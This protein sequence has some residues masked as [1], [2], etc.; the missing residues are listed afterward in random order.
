MTSEHQHRRSS[1]GRREG[2][3]PFLG[4]SQKIRK[5]IS[6]APPPAYHGPDEPGPL[7]LLFS[8]RPR[9]D[10]MQLDL[11]LRPGLLRG[12][13][14]SALMAICGTA[15]AAAPSPSEGEVS[16]RLYVAVPGI[17]NYLEYGGH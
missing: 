14:L 7:S 10:A 6:P 13:A 4:L 2:A 17:R 16:R 5:P 1:A 9:A 3:A 15:T 8:T 11:R 12:L